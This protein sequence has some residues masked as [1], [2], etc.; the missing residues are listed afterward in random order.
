M[1]QDRLCCCHPE[2]DTQLRSSWTPVLHYVA[3]EHNWGRRIIEIF[4]DIE[5][6]FDRMWH[7]ELLH[8]LLANIQI[9][10]AIVRTVLSF[11]EGRSFF[12]AVEDTTSDPRPI[13]TGVLQGSCLSP[14]LYALFMDNISTLAEQLQNWKDVILALYADNSAYLSSSRGAN[15]AVAKLQTSTYFQ[16]GWTNGESP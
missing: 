2:V 10:P 15:L 12:A 13:L 8:K 4:L 7:S 11:L 6:V 1:L 5:K 9:L 14:R 16:I 3:T